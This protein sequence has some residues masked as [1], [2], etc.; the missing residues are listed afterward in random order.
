MMTHI[1]NPGPFQS[2]PFYSGAAISDNINLHNL[3][4]YTLN[5]NRFPKSSISSKYLAEFILA[6]QPDLLL[7]QEIKDKFAFAVVM[8]E[9]NCCCSDFFYHWWFTFNRVYQSYRAVIYKS[10]LSPSL[11]N[12]VV[13]EEYYLDPPFI[14]RPPAVSDFFVDNCFL[15]LLNIHGAP[16]GCTYESFK[17]EKFFLRLSDYVSACNSAYPM[18]I[19][20]DFNVTYAGILSYFDSN[21]LKINFDSD[22]NGLDYSLC[23]SNFFNLIPSVSLSQSYLK[24]DIEDNPVFSDWFTDF[25]DHFPVR[26]DLLF[27]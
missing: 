13:D 1:K 27:S 19:F 26:L 24:S 25:S 7:L 11:F 18:L 4:F 2:V 10:S 5:L 17:K 16:Y 23:S 3:H 6:Y 9:I 15:R 22:Y 21:V 20:G 14:L 12:Y 8:Q